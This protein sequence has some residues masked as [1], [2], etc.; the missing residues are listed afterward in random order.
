MGHAAGALRALQRLGSTRQNRRGSQ[1]TAVGLAFCAIASAT[2][3]VP[4][5]S[6]QT[7]WDDPAFLLYRKAVEAMD[8][9][10]YAR[11]AELAV[12]AAKLFPSHVL[13]HYLRGQ[14][15]AAHARWADAATAFERVIELYPSS[16]AGHRDLGASYEHLGRADDA[17]RAWEQAL[18]LENSD[19]VRTSL[20]FLLLKDGRRPQALRHLTALADRGSARPEVWTAIAR[21]SYD[22]GD[23]AASEQAFV[24][25]VALRDD[26][27]AS[28]NLGVVSLR[29][30]N[31]PG[32]LEAFERAAQHADT[33]DQAQREISRLRDAAKPPAPAASPSAPVAP[34]PAPR[35]A[36]P[37]T[38]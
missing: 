21:L 32:A 26:G 1:W 13:A 15:A 25:A 30:H 12:E 29:L 24:R 37:R 9:K 19:D 10:D 27:R 33:R 8:R 4:S 14:A 7:L 6:A 5:A 34:S 22:A 28:F 38:R 23:L 31:S 11:A 18:E 20:A 35:P 2:A 3:G 36:V 16:F 17:A